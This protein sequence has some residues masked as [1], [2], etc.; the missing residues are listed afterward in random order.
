MLTT[1]YITNKLRRHRLQK[2]KLNFLIEQNSS[3]SYGL[4]DV[5]L[6]IAI[7]ILHTFEKPDE[8]RRGKKII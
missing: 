3:Q 5:R 8:K 6:Y 4:L 7:A 2:K 1:N